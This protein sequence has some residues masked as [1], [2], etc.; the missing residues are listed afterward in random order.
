M[1][2]RRVHTAPRHDVWEHAFIRDYKA[3]ERAHYIEACFRNIDWGVRVGIEENAGDGPLSKAG[4]R[5]SQSLLDIRAGRAGVDP[6]APR[7]E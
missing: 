2:S 5:P 3:T 1:F 7:L 6:D 4:E